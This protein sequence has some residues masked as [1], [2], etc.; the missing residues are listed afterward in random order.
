MADPQ[1]DARLAASRARALG[2]IRRARETILHAMGQHERLA[3]LDDFEKVARGR[4]EAER[5]ELEDLDRQ[6]AILRAELG[7]NERG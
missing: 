1:L 2:N 4:I 7:A 6:E 3:M 5:L